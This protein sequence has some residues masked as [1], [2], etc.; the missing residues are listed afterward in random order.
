M[1]LKFYYTEIVYQKEYAHKCSTQTHWS[2]TER[3]EKKGDHLS[4]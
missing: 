3:E 4:I 2:K 1:C